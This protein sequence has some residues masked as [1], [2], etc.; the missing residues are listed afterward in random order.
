[1]KNAD[2]KMKERLEKEE[3]EVTATKAVSQYELFVEN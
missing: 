3:Y 2:V 1:M